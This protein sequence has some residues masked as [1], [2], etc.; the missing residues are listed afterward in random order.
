[1][2]K[3]LAYICFATALLA[4]CSNEE[5]AE[6]LPQ[7]MGRIAVRCGAD[8]T[9]DTRATALPAGDDFSL[10]LSLSGDDYAESWATVAEFAAEER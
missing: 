3:R 8:L 9:V 4:G 2:K 10:S 1:M 6:T 5:Q 7:G